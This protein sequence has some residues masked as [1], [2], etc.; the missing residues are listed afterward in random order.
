MRTSH[1]LRNPLMVTSSIL[2][3]MLLLLPMQVAFPQSGWLS[4]RSLPPSGALRAVC[5][6]D[7]ST[8]TAVGQNGRIL[9]TTNGGTSWMAQLGG[10]SSELWGVWFRDINNGIAVG[11]SGTILQTTN[12][13]ETWMPQTSG[14][15]D[16]L[17]GVCF[18]DAL[19]GAAV[20]MGGTILLTHDGGGTWAIQDYGPG[21][22]LIAV[23]YKDPLT[24]TA[25]G[26]D[27]TIVRSPDGGVSWARSTCPASALWAMSFAD[28]NNGVVV[29][30]NGAILRTTD[31]GETWNSQQSGTTSRLHGISFVDA[32]TG[33]AV[34][35]SRTIL[36]T[37]NGGDTWTIQTPPG[38]TPSG[39]W[40]VSF[41]DVNNGTIVSDAGYA[42]GTTNGGAT[43]SLK[44]STLNAGNLYGVWFRETNAGIAVGD[45]GTILRTTDGG[46]N[47]PRVFS[48]VTVPLWSAAFIDPNSGWAVGE[49]GTILHTNDAGVTWMNVPS[50]TTNIL[51]GVCFA[52]ANTGIAVGDGG[53]ILRTNSGGATWFTQYSGSTNS[54]YAASFGDANNGFAVGIKG[55]ILRT[56]NGGITWTGQ[57]V[58]TISYLG[59]AF[60]DASNGTVVGASGT[61]LRTNDGG[62][63]W[64]RQSSGRTSNLRSVVFMDVNTGVIV[65]DAGLILRTTDGGNTWATDP[66]GTTA[67]LYSVSFSDPAR[68][69]VVGSNG[70]IV[71]TVSNWSPLLKI[72]ENP[73]N[74]A[75]YSVGMSSP[76][77]Y[78]FLASD[79]TP[80]YVWSLLAG[81]LPPGLMLGETGVIFGMPTSAGTSAFTIQVVDANG[82][83]A[84]KGVT[85]VIA[86]RLTLPA[87]TTLPSSPAGVARSDTLAIV[88]GVPPYTCMLMG[89]IPPG[90][91][92]SNGGV[93]SGIPTV[94]GI[95]DFSV[96]V[97]DRYGSRSDGNVHMTIT[98]SQTPP[99][100]L[101][102]NLV[103]YY[104]FNGN[105]KDESG[106]GY[107]GTVN[108]ATPIADR[109]GTPNSAYS[110]DGISASIQTE[111]IGTL[112]AHERALSFWMKKP[113][114]AVVPHNMFILGY[115]GSFAQTVSGSTFLMEYPSE[116][117]SNLVV[118]TDIQSGYIDYRA[119]KDDTLWHHYCVVVPPMA[120]PTVADV[121]IYQDGV[122][123]SSI[124]RSEGSTTPI[125]T[126]SGIPFFMGGAGSGYF[127]GALDDVRIYN[128]ALIQAEISQLYT[129][130]GWIA[131][132]PPQAPQNLAATI[133][134]GQV[135]LKWSRN[136]E[137]DFLRYRIYRGA[138][139]GSEILV[140]SS[141]SSVTDT[142]GTFVG[143]TNGA[144][145]FFK[146]T[147][148]NSGG[149][150]SAYSSELS[151]TPA[152]LNVN[153]EYNTDGNTVLL[154]HMDESTGSSVLDASGNGNNATS[155]GDAI[156]AGRFGN[157]RSISPSDSG[158]VIDRGLSLIE[159]ASASME[160]WVRISEYGNAATFIATT[161]EFQLVLGSYGSSG[162]VQFYRKSGSQWVFA[163][164]S[165]RIP[166]NEWTHVAGSWDGST[167]RLW[168]N[169]NPEIVTVIANPYVATGRSRVASFLSNLA[170]PTSATYID[171]VRISNKARQAQEFNIHLPPINL[172]ASVSGT[173]ASL[174][175]QN[176][177]G[178]VPLLR[179]KIYR[180]ADSTSVTLIDSTS[181]TGFSNSGM[182]GGMSYYYRVSAVDITGFEG[183]KSY[184]ARAV[185]PGL[186]VRLINSSGMPLAGGSLRYYDASWK[187]ATNNNDGTFSV[188]T[189]LK[190]VSL[191]MTY[192]SGS[193]TKSNV[194]VG[195][196]VVVFQTVN[197]LVKL[198]NSAG[199]SIDTG[200]VQY[201][202]SSWRDFGVTTN[203]TASKEL[204]PG[205]YTFRMIYATASN[206]KQQDISSNPSVVFTTVNAA[207]QLKNSQ[208]SYLDQGNVQYYFS[209]WQTF[210]PTVNGVAT[211]ELL[212]GNY[213][214]RMTYASAS[215]DKQQNIGTNP[216][217]VFQ[218]VNTAVQLQNSQGALIDTGTVQYY[219]SSWQNF[220]TTLNGV[221]TKELLP[222][223]Y[224]FR[225]SYASATKDRQQNI[226]TNS[227]VV[228]N[229]MSAN[230]QL[231]N[232]QGVLMD[233]GTVQYYF[234]AWKTFGSTTNGVV[235]KEL[236][237]ASYT[238][239]MNY[240]TV[241]N[242]KVQDISTN[243]TV[244]FSTLFCRVRV[245]NLQGQL[246]DG[247]LASYYF[248]SWRQ[249]G[250]TTGGE[251]T[252]ELLPA[253]LTFRL[254]L[255][256]IRQ[257]KVQNI[258]SN[259][260]VLFTIQ[261]GTQAAMEIMLPDEIAKM[262][263]ELDVP[264]EFAVFQNFPNPF[265]P[266][267]T[268]V[269]HV[270]DAS[271]VHVEIY[272]SMGQLVRELI[273]G[274][275][276]PGVYAVRWDGRNNDGVTVS[277]GMYFCRVGSA[278]SVMSKRMLL[279]K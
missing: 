116:R 3:A 276:D 84:N 219:S 277:S 214:F 253:N 58:G 150:E 218:T 37:T 5:F 154:L 201:Y 56:T 178:L 244:T 123:L 70:N 196:D 175:W 267:T 160:A 82:A 129:E 181:S 251:V 248:S 44:R 50:G 108:G 80:P 67:S 109:F 69:T 235:S 134:N 60:T 30:D 72:I 15:T 77:P 153:R 264:K 257:D 135:T 166:L 158:V 250:V 18:S 274:T 76:P 184:A 25:L 227:I 240:E 96:A 176:G 35:E 24:I 6:T 92:L 103:A 140:D 256:A 269:Y 187:D 207:V 194:S 49:G 75:G 231:K 85:M 195:P 121:K 258:G 212:P 2:L 172:S 262:I 65:G 142:S 223:N 211:K 104:P 169:G 133:G 79:G 162:Y 234:N 8:G 217:V 179:Y 122:L 53:T 139:S 170:A 238:F 167:Y 161:N 27:G 107:N 147:A 259:N 36:R 206:D 91:S 216:T 81:S 249:I 38:G 46:A 43:W 42:V 200:K 210:G 149:L 94:S 263:G 93:L 192:E 40:A 213:T 73:G 226:G 10:T 64:A 182:N 102:A 113:V 62:A 105:A 260:L 245:E 114:T 45:A 155:Y 205:N 4:Q 188:T 1:D 125:N 157:G 165:T 74:V 31:G 124:G 148:V 228:F 186:T 197:T 71:R 268:I 7:A 279:L 19:N 229:T 208:G 247:A 120:Q 59:V 189:N 191:R 130:G 118:G 236:L 193:Q 98:A 246:V 278:G 168:I 159:G 95:Y 183:G 23:S 243:T 137:S 119:T 275:Q 126:Q 20:G 146:V 266:S 110:F 22:S 9:R 47:W 117:V 39:L 233:Q 270:A 136:T 100:N 209:S 145:Y 86:D 265:N 29:G 99:N 68:G 151:V 143:L 111:L 128:R 34:G 152:V 61:I 230:V 242:D 156:V 224:T 180:G 112:G 173:T 132:T 164:S 222:A 198:Q 14:T 273:S 203:G 185:L 63:T 51:R 17:V 131:N 171:E 89:P 220:G 54:L 41:T 101:P 190:T 241:T 255:G 225:I 87:N 144:T 202:Y 221:T 33:T 57:T 127:V 28:V 55:T 232:S 271:T 204:L 66:S 32:N 78:T 26:M 138:S 163:M 97:F 177:G 115:G 254:S 272:N 21:T 252:K 16:N 141:S 239:R 199:A 48:G 11:F 12:S 174:S 52:D 106:N 13:G 90:M 83:M 237:P 215:N 88:G 261:P